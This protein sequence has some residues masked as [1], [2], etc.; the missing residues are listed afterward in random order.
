MMP[1]IYFEN[2]RLMWSFF[3]VLALAGC[4]VSASESRPSGGTPMCLLW[5]EDGS[6][7]RYGHIHYTHMHSRHYRLNGI[8]YSCSLKRCNMRSTYII[9]SIYAILI[10]IILAPLECKKHHQPSNV[11]LNQEKERAVDCNH[12]R[13]WQGHAA[14]SGCFIP[15]GCVH[16]YIPRAGW[17]SRPSVPLIH[18]TRTSDL[19]HLLIVPVWLCFCF[20]LMSPLQDSSG[21][22]LWKRKWFVLSEFCLFY[23]KGDKRHSPLSWR[24]EW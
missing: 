3:R 16:R 15:F 20:P 21:M 19:S 6:T 2:G 11:F 13:S 12:T 8:T 22:R 4:T 5:S 7:N 23:Y 17:K 24:L 1:I 10:H 9:F 18:R 14:C